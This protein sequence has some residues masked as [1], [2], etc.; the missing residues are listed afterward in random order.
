MS[1]GKE[2]SRVPS[3]YA[4]VLK[5]RGFNLVE[6]IGQ[7]AYGSVYRATQESLGKRS[8][9]VKFFDRPYMKD[10]ANRK[11][12]EREGPL[13][14]RVEHPSIPYVVTTGTV[15][16]SGDKIPY[17]VMQ[18]VR[19]ESLEQQIRK[20]KKFEPSFAVKTMT[21]VLS[22]LA[23]AHESKVV[24]RDVKPD[25]IITGANST[26]LIDFSIGICLEYQPGLTRLT[27][28]G[29]RVGTTEYASP[30]Q[31]KDAAD[32]DH[33]TDIYSAGVVL[34]EMLAGNSRIDV[35][36]IAGQ[37]PN[38]PI[39]LRTIISKA[40]DQDRERRYPSAL[41]FRKA[42]EEFSGGLV[43]Q[44]LEPMLSLCPYPLCDGANWSQTGYLRG[45][46]IQDSTANVCCEHCGTKYIKNC[47]GCKK[48]LPSN[49]RQLLSKTNKHDPDMT[50]AHCGHCGTVLYKTI[51]CMSCGSFLKR[52][53]I[54][55]DTQKNGCSKNC[56]NNR[57]TTPVT[58]SADDDIPF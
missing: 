14:A 36:E 27:G 39:G 56:K 53:N 48:P 28:Q 29:H 16:R 38:T 10:A 41:E 25:N 2:H 58:Y 44:A 9:A 40:C 49:I 8:V 17:M 52:V 45:P 20:R 31:L 30:E 5:K 3:E 11:R 42:L 35:S 18:F 23:C 55:K 26:Y 54:G 6:R 37:L 22:A 33:R 46:N 47:P 13:M 15:D 4:E 24:H 7:G 43:W 32:V 19:G 21:A 1:M 12:F 34:F 51:K 57:E 50:E